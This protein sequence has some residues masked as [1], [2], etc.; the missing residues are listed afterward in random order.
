MIGGRR[1]AR[2]IKVANDENRNAK[3]NTSSSSTNVV[4][5]SA[6]ASVVASST[7]AVRSALG[8]LSNNVRRGVDGRLGKGKATGD[9]VEKPAPV[10]HRRL[11]TAVNTQ[12]TSIASRLSIS[13]KPSVRP[14]PA[15]SASVNITGVITQNAN[16]APVRPLP[17]RARTLTASNLAAP[18]KPAPAEDVMEIEEVDEGGD[19]ELDEPKQAVM[20]VL[21]EADEEE[22]EEQKGHAKVTRQRSVQIIDVDQVAEPDE[23][24]WTFASP[25]TNARY[26]AA[27]EE[28]RATFKDEIDEFDMTMVS[29]YSE[30]IFEYMAKLEVDSMA[31]PTYMDGQTEIA[32]DMRKTLVDWLL[33]VHLRYHML[34]ET[35]WIAINIVDRF[36]S[37][38][39]VSL[40]KLQLVG[41][42]AMFVASKYEE[43]MAPSVE[44]FSFMT[45]N[46]YSREE[47]LKG[48]KII[49]QTLEFNISAYCSP[50]TWVRRISKADDY[51]IQTRTLCKFLMEVT[52][53]DHRFLRA[54]P[55]LVAAIGMYTS[56][57]MLS[58]SW[59]EAFIFY[60]NF[61]EEQL[62]PGFHLLLENLA[63]PDFDK[64]FV[65]KKYANK[66]FLKAS[67]YARDWAVNYLQ[68]SSV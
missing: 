52:L 57:R 53:L 17:S 58:G 51:D 35:L 27:V 7:G 44:E 54:K 64:G 18:P 21:E 8:E 32:W 15:R 28:I 6:K 25:A 59:D 19:T 61:N 11:S 37:R 34:P 14:A 40:V 33:Q 45:E 60:S 50:Y 13:S 16:G 65:C 39:V 24:D 10:V 31:N 30:E 47:I 20:E 48:E 56:K 12:R 67:L 63:E 23:D 5:A 2:R 46:T 9:A 38:R 22:I 36:L 62:V 4:V 41:V 26:Q 49:L 29:E 43:I 68:E 1:P 42:T 55:S 66:K 3:V